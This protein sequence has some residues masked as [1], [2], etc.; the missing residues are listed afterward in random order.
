MI[1]WLYYPVVCDSKK[2]V[3][4]SITWHLQQLHCM[5]EMYNSQAKVCTIAVLIPKQLQ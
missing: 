1:V 2:D 3:Q 4:I 5:D